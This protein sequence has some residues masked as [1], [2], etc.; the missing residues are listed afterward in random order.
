MTPLNSSRLPIVRVFVIVAALLSLLVSSDVGP[1]FLPLP[2]LENQAAEHLQ[3][4]AGAT[5]SSLYSKGSS[6]FRV[7]MAQAQKRSD[8]ELQGQP[9][10]VMPGTTFVP[11]N[12]TRI[13]T[14]LCDPDVLHTVALTSLPSGRGPPRPV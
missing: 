9:L 3:Q 13:F 14:A 5:A 7:P 11:P 1:R 6:S 12:K 2:T 4:P 10:A 8:R